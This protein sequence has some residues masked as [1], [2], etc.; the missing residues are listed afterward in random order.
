M[1]NLIQHS[2]YYFCKSCRKTW[3]ATSV[4]FDREA[5]GQHLLFGHPYF[6]DIHDV[7]YV[8]PV[9]KRAYPDILKLADEYLVRSSLK[10]N[11]IEYLRGMCG[12]S[13]YSM[14]TFFEPVYSVTP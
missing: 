3:F 4:L 6:L 2:S 5:A 11:V 13:T 12:V 10:E 8:L 1:L 14:G 9:V 7:L